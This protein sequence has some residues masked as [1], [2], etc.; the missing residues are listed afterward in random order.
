MARILLKPLLIVIQAYGMTKWFGI[1]LPV[2][3]GVTFASAAPMVAMADAQP[4]VEGARMIFGAIDWRMAHGLHPLLESGI[5]LTSIT[6]VLLNFFFNGGKA[7]EAGA[8]EA[9]KAAEAH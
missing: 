3:M 1:K 2:M 6:A 9:A 8:I 4:G 7:D 5:L